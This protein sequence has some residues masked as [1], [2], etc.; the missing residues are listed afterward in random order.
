MNF[1]C[2]RL[3]GEISVRRKANG[4]LFATELL[5]HL[6][7]FQRNYTAKEKRLR[8]R[9]GLKFAYCFAQM[10]PDYNRLE[11]SSST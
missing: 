9:C 2:M 6:R 4:F 10:K 8:G 1:S 3:D 11:I 5:T 7:I